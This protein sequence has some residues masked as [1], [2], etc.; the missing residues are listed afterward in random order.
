MDFDLRLLRHARALGE[1]RNFARAARTLRL[2]Q[3]ALS[4]SIQDLER[5][6]GIKLFD[7][8]KG[9]VEPTDLG[10]IFL[11]HA[12][13]LMGRAEALD[14]EVWGA[15]VVLG[16]GA[17]MSAPGYLDCTDWAIFDSQEG[18]AEYLLDQF[19]PEEE[20]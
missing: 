19:G 16:F 4:R 7:R 15:A 12:R 9:R 18:A 3:P 6:T 10:R 1:E 13:E 14:R 17:R 11:A 2:T 20:V 5:R 8:N